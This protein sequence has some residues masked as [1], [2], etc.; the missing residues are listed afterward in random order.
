VSKLNA[1]ARLTRLC[2]LCVIVGTVVTE[3]VG[4]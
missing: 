4:F 3:I 1:S 2:T